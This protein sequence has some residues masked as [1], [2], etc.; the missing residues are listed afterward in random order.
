MKPNED[1]ELDEDALDSEMDSDEMDSDEMDSDEGDELVEIPIVGELGDNQTELHE[2]L[3]AV[4]PG[5][6]CTLYFNS[7]GG[8][9]YCALSLMTLIRYRKL[10]C[11]AVVTGE[12]SSAALWPFAACRRRLVTPLSVFLF[13]A[14]KWESAENIGYQEALQWSKHFQWLAVDTEALLAKMLGLPEMQVE[15]WVREGCYVTGPELATLGC[16]ELIDPD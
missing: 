14:A 3:L 9:P 6:E 1:H 10:Q 4:P 7:P 15:K 2:K 8:D 11:T 13:H 12:C 5:G 16:A